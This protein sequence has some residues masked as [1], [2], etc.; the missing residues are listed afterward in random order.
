MLRMREQQKISTW[1]IFAHAPAVAAIT[2]GMTLASVHEFT[3]SSAF[4]MN[5]NQLIASGAT[6]NLLVAI[7]LYIPL[8]AGRLGGNVLAT[9]ISSGTMYLFC[10]ALS[11]LGTLI[12]LG[13]AGNVGMSVL[14]AAITSL[15]VGNYFSQMYDY[16]TKKNPQFQREISVILAITMALAGGLTVPA[17]HLNAWFG[18]TNLDIWYALAALAASWLLTL[19]MMDN[20]TIVKFMKSTWN[21]LN[22]KLFRK[23][24][25]QNAA[26]EAPGAVTKDMLAMPWEEGFSLFSSRGGEENFHY[27]ANSSNKKRH[28]LFSNKRIDQDPLPN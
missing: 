16:V 15:G 17:S 23:S 22:E 8:I 28:S 14:G 27:K 12:M 25:G 18:G 1:E 7:A 3:I 11:G 10:N 26:Q 21:T 19:G 20:S 13:S 24:T 5:L 9:R 2:F 6:A 4:A